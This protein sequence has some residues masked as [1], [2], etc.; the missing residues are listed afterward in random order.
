MQEISIQQSIEP[1]LT[2]LIKHIH[3]F[4][5]NF[6]IYKTPKDLNLLQQKQNQ[7][8]KS[9]IQIEEFKDSPPSIYQRIKQEK[10][11]C[12]ES[13]KRQHQQREIKIAA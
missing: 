3:E 11:R 2:D 10:Q 12:N 9:N 8:Q 7:T 1:K 5:V 4:P 13:W 6:T